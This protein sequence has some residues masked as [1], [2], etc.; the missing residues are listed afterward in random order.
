[1]FVYVYRKGYFGYL[2]IVEA[3]GLLTL[4]TEEMRMDIL[5]MVV[6]LAMAE[7]IA[8]SLT[9]PFNDMHEMVLT[10]ECQ[11]TEDI[12][13]VDGQNLRF[14]L[15]ERHRAQACGQCPHHDDAVRRRLDTVFLQQLCTI[16]L[17]HT[18]AKIRQKCDIDAFFHFFLNFDTN[19]TVI[20]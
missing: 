17:V 15:C 12:R 2:R 9:A 8:H 5:I 3:I 10:E 18:V 16:S 1:M 20:P 7:F 4:F 14:Q 19:D 11:C 6:I 13:L